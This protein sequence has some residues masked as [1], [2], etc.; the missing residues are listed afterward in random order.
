MPEDEFVQSA[1]VVETPYDSFA[2]FYDRYW[3]EPLREWQAPALRRMLLAELRPGAKILDLCC[4]AGH[5][6]RELVALGYGVTGVDSSE[7]MLRLARKKAPG[8]RFVRADATDFALQERVDAAVC[9]FD[10]L[11]H[12]MDAESIARVFRNVH[13]SLKPGGA[14]VFDIN[15]G[16][17]YGERWGYSSYEIQPDHSFIL[18][19]QFD[20]VERVGVTEITM[21]RLLGTWQRHD[22]TI[23]QRPWEKDEIEPLLRGAGFVDIASYLPQEDFGMSGHYGIGRVFLKACSSMNAAT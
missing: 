11:N 15:S 9:V 3:A 13:A 4:G 5:L 7:E 23:R 10:S 22:T 12:F 2:W 17:A 14:F 21:F 18:R 8:A 20:P 16:S 1:A 19:G 6:A